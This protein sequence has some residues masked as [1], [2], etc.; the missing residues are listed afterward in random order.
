M[1]LRV[2][3]EKFN[4][5]L[6]ELKKLA[7]VVEVSTTARDVAEQYIDLGARLK[8]LRAQEERL[9]QLLQQ[10]KTVEGLLKVGDYLTRVRSSIEWHEAQLKNLERGVQFSSVRVYIEA[11]PREVKP[12]VAFPSF[13][14]TPA[15]ASALGLL[16]SAIYGAIVLLIGLSPLTLAGASGHLAYTKLKRRVKAE[17]A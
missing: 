6:E 8:A 7:S 9:L 17:Q 15:L 2:P 5:T 13:D 14:P 12:I 16:Y 3:Q 10:A 11:P 1:L 4:K